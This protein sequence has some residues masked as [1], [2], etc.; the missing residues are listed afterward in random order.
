MTR[1]LK[2]PAV[3]VCT[4]PTWYNLG[5]P[6]STC[7][8]LL[9]VTIP[10][11]LGWHPAAPADEGLEILPSGSRGWPHQSRIRGDLSSPELQTNASVEV[12]PQTAVSVFTPWVSPATLAAIAQYWLPTCISCR[13]ISIPPR[14]IWGM[15]AKASSA[16]C[17]R[18]VMKPLC[19]LSRRPVLGL[20]PY[21]LFDA[22]NVID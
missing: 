8:S 15:W 12:H 16:T 3:E 14:P 6:I 13:P 9:G 2:I 10:L 18:P 20:E 22:S 19:T 21:L 1:T 7:P 17:L 4:A 5:F 11:I